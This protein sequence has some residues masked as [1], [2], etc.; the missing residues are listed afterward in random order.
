MVRLD[1]RR[2]SIRRASIPA[3]VLCCVCL[4]AT[5]TSAG[6]IFTIP[7]DFSEGISFNDPDAVEFGGGFDTPQSIS[8]DVAKFRMS[9]DLSFEYEIVATVTTSG[10]MRPMIDIQGNLNARGLSDFGGFLR[11]RV[12][13]RIQYGFIVMEKSAPPMPMPGVPILMHSR[14]DVSASGPATAGVTALLPNFSP[15]SLTTLSGPQEFDRLLTTIVNPGDER[16]VRLTAFGDVSFLNEGQASFQ[17]VVDPLIEIDPSFA[18]KDN[19][20]I[21]FGS[22]HVFAGPEPAASV[23]EPGSLTLLALGSLGLAFRFRKPARCSQ[24]ALWAT[25]GPRR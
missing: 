17:A 2:A 11:G 1:P 12:S 9:G 15:I 19:Y 16:L 22:A 21:L 14:G 25:E 5:D 13:A 8:V 24:S 10:G 6:P 3:T 4:V 23:P 7:T 20:E 18:F